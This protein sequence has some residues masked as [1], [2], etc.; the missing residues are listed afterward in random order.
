[1][2]GTHKT[3]VT[4]DGSDITVRYWATDI[5]TVSG[6]T[7]RLNTGGY[8]TPTTKRRMN[9][10]S[11]HF[12]LGFQVYQKD[13]QWYARR[14][15]GDILPFHGNSLEIERTEDSWIDPPKGHWAHKPKIT[16]TKTSDEILEDIKDLEGYATEVDGHNIRLEGEAMEAYMQARKER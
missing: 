10:A 7:V 11:E 6:D 1:M 12:G 9:E 16:E 3:R 8:F 2:I 4:R 5:V 14:P 15:N 13:F